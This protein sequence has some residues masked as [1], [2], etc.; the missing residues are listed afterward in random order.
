M[1]EK[2]I[3]KKMK[4]LKTTKPKANKLSS[5]TYTSTRSKLTNKI[6]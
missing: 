5:S 6:L 3:L 1:S 4:K 2:S